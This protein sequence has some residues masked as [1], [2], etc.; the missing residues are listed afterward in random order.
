[1]KLEDI[2]SLYLYNLDNE[3]YLYGVSLGGPEIIATMDCVNDYLIDDVYFYNVTYK[4]GTYPVLI[5]KDGIPLESLPYTIYEISNYTE[6]P[7]LIDTAI[8][9]CNYNSQ[10]YQEYYTQEEIDNLNVGPY[11]YYFSLM[12]QHKRE[13]EAQ[14]SQMNSNIVQV[15]LPAP[16]ESITT[17][18]TETL[19]MV[20][21]SNAKREY[22]SLEEIFEDTE[23]YHP[24]YTDGT[25]LVIPRDTVPN[26]KRTLELLTYYSKH[27]GFPVSYSKVMNTV[28]SLRR[29]KN[30][31]D[32]EI[33]DILGVDL[34][35]YGTNINYTDYHIGP[36]L[37]KYSDGVVGEE[38]YRTRTKIS[39]TKE[40]I[41]NLANDLE[42]WINDYSSK[43]PAVIIKYQTCLDIVRKVQELN[44]I[45]GQ[46]SSFKQIEDG[47]TYKENVT[48]DEND[49]DIWW[50]HPTITLTE[51]NRF[52]TR[53]PQ[54]QGK[55]PIVKECIVAPKG[56][57]VMAFDIS[58][59]DVYFLVWSIMDDE[60]LKQ[61]TQ[62]LGSPYLAILKVL[63]Y[64]QTKRNKDI[65]KVP[66][67]AIM[68]GMSVDTLSKSLKPGTDE[69]EM[70]H[71]I[72]NYIISNS[73]YKNIALHADNEKYSSD[74][75]RSDVFGVSRSIIVEDGPVSKVRARIKR[76][77]LNGFFQ[78]SAASLLSMSID[79]MVYDLIHQSYPGPQSRP[80][81]TEDI[82]PV[83]TIHDECVVLVKDDIVEEGK[84]F[85]EYYMMPQ[86]EGW[87]RVS[88]GLTVGQ[89]YVHK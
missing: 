29:E 49:E 20:K 3:K 37:N 13:I 65:A 31:I 76:Q 19:N 40:K 45:N 54:I 42:R 50:F 85:L 60:E 7:A 30:A 44:E 82:I 21:S 62:E 4:T 18:D 51:T 8:N 69:E 35:V 14:Y 80:F 79:R 11:L 2:K 52:T 25:T 43:D 72:Y 47:L 38:Y 15:D 12:T 9:Y 1:M 58:A 89:H 56:Y 61:Y 66:T 6:Y 23:M 73:G 68:N 33:K 71:N 53:D 48:Q 59:Q 77:V 70:I 88:G 87:G 24:I 46:L 63:G 67:L 5:T 34:I 10:K 22:N 55:Q 28:S 84:L 36:L 86:I 64:E 39:F 27:K 41:A 83:V 75:K 78:M 57:K 32:R 16:T 81:T 26:I 74:P 17:D